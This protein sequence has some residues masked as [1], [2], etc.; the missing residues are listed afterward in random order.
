MSKRICSVPSCPA[1]IDSTERG[2]CLE[3]RRKVE[4]AR[5]TSTQRGYGTA[6]QRER[7]RWVPLVATGNVPCRRCERPLAPGEPFDLGHPDDA[8]KRPTAPECVPC[9]RAA[10]RYT[11]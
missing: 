4:Q 1:I 11:A 6:H 7:K 10:P 9:N 2:R 8:C 5:G 3:H